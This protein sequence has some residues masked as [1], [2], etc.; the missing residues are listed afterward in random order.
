MSPE[1]LARKLERLGAFLADLRPH[2]D[3]PT[4]DI[5][6]DPY[7]VER[8]LELLVQV[9]VDILAHQLAERGETPTSYRAVFERAG[10]KALIGEDL[11]RRLADA[12]GLRN[13]LVHLYEDI[14]YGIVA[15]SVGKAIDDF[16]ELLD[17]LSASL[18][19]ADGR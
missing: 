5:R 15:A 10:Q 4:E 1:V 8:L 2:R 6:S 11:S 7:E 14:D 3:R 9:A 17:A 19:E 16:G 12:A 13:V 18:D